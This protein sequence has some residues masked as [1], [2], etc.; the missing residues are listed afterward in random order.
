M[1]K[2]FLLPFILLLA[3]LLS[4]CACGE[5]ET[6]LDKTELALG[7]GEQ[8][9]LTIETSAK[10][11]T[12]KSSDEAVVTV[13]A[14][15]KTAT[16]TALAEGEAVITVESGGETLASCSVT[17]T[18]FLSFATTVPEG[19]LVLRKDQVISVP[20]K[21]YAPLPQEDYVWE[22]SDTTIATLEYQGSLARIKAVKRGECTITVRNGSYT[23][24]FT[25]IVGLT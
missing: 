2:R 13:E 15:G 12:W 21:S 14:N 22:S 20:V 18:A 23:A 10:E 8:S 6:K 17:V 3:V 4:L 25:L 19:K 7:I 9:T 11:L 16:L 5:K 1:K 24:S